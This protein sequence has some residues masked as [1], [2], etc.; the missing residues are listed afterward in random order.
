MAGVRRHAIGIA[1]D[2]KWPSIKAIPVAGQSERL[3]R[4]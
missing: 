4:R 1:I 3:A 2:E